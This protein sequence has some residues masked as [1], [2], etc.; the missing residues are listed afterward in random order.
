MATD[1]NTAGYRAD[2]TLYAHSELL[3]AALDAVD[4][5][6][7]SGFQRDYMTALV[8]AAFGVEAY[9]NFAIEELPLSVALKAPMPQKM[10]AVLKHLNLIADRS[11]R[12]F[13]SMDRVRVIRN[14][15]AHARTETVS[16]VRDGPVVEPIAYPLLDWEKACTVDVAPQLVDDVWAA[17]KTIHRATGLMH[18]APGMLEERGG[19]ILRRNPHRERPN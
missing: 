3:L 17:L 12:P 7:E 15:I 11:R 5:G 8:L 10:D 1:D 19:E 14:K 2:R 9:L 13:D 16:E 4:R 18:G 6:R